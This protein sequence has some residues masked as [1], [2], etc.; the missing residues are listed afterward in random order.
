VKTVR[1]LLI[2][3]AVAVGSAAIVGMASPVFAFLH[4]LPLL[5]VAVL[6]LT[7]RFVGEKRL[8]ARLMAVRRVPRPV[9]RR[10][11]HLRER[12]LSSIATRSTPHLRGPPATLAA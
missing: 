1:P 12:A 4:W 9:R 10:W 8:I 3:V 7:R 2:A 11:S 6:L 5:V